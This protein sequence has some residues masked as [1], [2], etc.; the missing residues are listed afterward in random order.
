MERYPR[1]VLNV[2]TKGFHVDLTDIKYILTFS[3]KSFHQFL[4]LF[5]ISM[6]S[7]LVPHY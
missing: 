1:A 6:P 5:M 3:D 7:Y 4:I 2:G